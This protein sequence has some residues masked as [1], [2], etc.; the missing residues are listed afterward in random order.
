MM[1]FVTRV[2]PWMTCATCAAL[3][4]ARVSA[5]SRAV[6]TARAGSSGVVSDLATV[7]SPVALSTRIRSVKVPPMSTPTWK[8]R[9]Y[10]GGRLGYLE[11]GK[12]STCGERCCASMPPS[13]TSIVPVT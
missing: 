4:R 1:A 10:L 3:T 13:T 7:K 5:S 12:M 11:S 8:P 9:N 2:V 6:A